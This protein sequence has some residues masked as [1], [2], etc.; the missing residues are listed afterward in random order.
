MLNVDL[1]RMKSE[2]MVAS[3]DSMNERLKAIEAESLSI[4]S[5]IAILTHE[6]IQRTIDLNR[7]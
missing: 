4:R 6:L 7:K 3:L 2:E 5:N 1:K